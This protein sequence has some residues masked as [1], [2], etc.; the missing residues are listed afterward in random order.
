MILFVGSVLYLSSHQVL[1]TFLRLVSFV[2]PAVLSV[3]AARS[4]IRFDYLIL[5]I[6]RVFA[7]IFVGFLVVCFLYKINRNPRKIFAVGKSDPN[8]TLNQFFGGR[9]GLELGSLSVIIL[10]LQ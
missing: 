4:I 6:N 7:E 2:R 10:L 1:R 9:V 3:G 5:S 8:I